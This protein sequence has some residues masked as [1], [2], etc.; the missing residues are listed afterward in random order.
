MLSNST[1]Y[2]P[3]WAF[4]LWKRVFVH[5]SDA[6]NKA[7]ANPQLRER[8]LEFLQRQSFELGQGKKVRKIV[9]SRMFVKLGIVYDRR[10]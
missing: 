2:S 5:L 4:I 10:Q 3:S 9:D 1:N 8:A 7:L 6:F